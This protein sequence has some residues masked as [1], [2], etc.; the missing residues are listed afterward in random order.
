M[1]KKPQLIKHKNNLVM[2]D[3]KKVLADHQLPKLP[4]PFKNVDDCQAELATPVGDTFMPKT[5]VIKNT[6]PKVHVKLGANL[7]PDAKDEI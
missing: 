5:S 7:E 6:K 1:K 4:H 3:A 2:K